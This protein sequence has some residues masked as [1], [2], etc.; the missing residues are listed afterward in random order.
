MVDFR[1][2]WTL[3]IGAVGNSAYQTRGAKVSIYFCHP[4]YF[5]YSLD[6]LVEATAGQDAPPTDLGHSEI[7][8]ETEN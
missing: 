3:Q 8:Q 1:I 7:G 5:S 6:L 2:N 4:P